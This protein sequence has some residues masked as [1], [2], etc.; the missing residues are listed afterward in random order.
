[1]TLNI[2]PQSPAFQVVNL[3]YQRLIQRET[4]STADSSLPKK[5]VKK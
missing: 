2:R 5:P 3:E 1:M 4:R